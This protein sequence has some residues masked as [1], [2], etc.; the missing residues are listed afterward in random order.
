MVYRALGVVSLVIGGIFALVA[1]LV[2][3]PFIDN[4]NTSLLVL[5]GVFGILAYVFLAIGWQLFHPPA[6]RGG[7]SEAEV[8]NVSAESESHTPVV[9]APAVRAAAVPVVP[10]IAADLPPTE[11]ES[12]SPEIPVGDTQGD[13]VRGGDADVEDTAAASSVPRSSPNG[14]TAD[15]AHPGPGR[16]RKPGAPVPHK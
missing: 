7:R 1:V 8:A 12:V 9:H 11:L 15:P 4:F 2:L 13:V 10:S 3:L 6:G 14:S 16:F 5:C